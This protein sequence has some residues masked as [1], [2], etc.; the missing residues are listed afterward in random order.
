VWCKIILALD[1]Q[2]VLRCGQTQFYLILLVSGH[3]SLLTCIRRKV[4]GH[5]RY[6]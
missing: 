6:Q 4:A 3:V 2:H 5:V 1:V